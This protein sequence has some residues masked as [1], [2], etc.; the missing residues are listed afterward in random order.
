VSLAGDVRPSPGIDPRRARSRAAIVDAAIELFQTDGVQA[1]SVEAICE[2]AGVSRRTFFNHFETRQHLHDR[3]A[4]QRSQQAADVL[5]AYAADPRPLADRL[6]EFL[7]TM[8]G[9][10]AA[11]PAYRDFVGEMLQRHPARGF[12]AV[13]GGELFDGVRTLLGSAVDRGELR[14]DG[15]IDA[16]ADVIVGAVVLLTANWSASDAFDVRAGARE[17]AAVLRPLCGGTT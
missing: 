9:Y 1:T 6:E 13:R 7:A 15:P 17:T 16:L 10:L 12:E 5:R 3:I 14:P 4:D 8:A 11:R 2:R